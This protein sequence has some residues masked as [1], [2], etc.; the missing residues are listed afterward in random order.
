MTF[1]RIEILVVAVGLK[2]SVVVGFVALL[3]VVGS[4]FLGQPFGPRLMA[5]CGCAL[6]MAFVAGLYLAACQAVLQKVRKG[7]GA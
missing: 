6:A 2:L 5:G 7:E 3:G 4:L 1:S